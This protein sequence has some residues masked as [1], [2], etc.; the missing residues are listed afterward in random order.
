MNAKERIKEFLAF[1]RIGQNKF[2]KDC[3]FSDSLINNSKGSI[4]SEVLNKISIRWPE[5]NL[6]W[7]ITGQGE[8]INRPAPDPDLATPVSLPLP[9]PLALPPPQPQPEETV[10]T[11]EICFYDASAAGSYE[12]FDEIINHEKLIEK[13]V[14]PPFKD[15]SWMIPVRG[16]AMYPTYSNGDM[17]ACRVLYESKIIQWGRV[18]AIATR[19]QGILVKRV[20]KSETEDCL[21]ALSDNPAYKPFDIPKSEVVGMALVLGVI[22]ME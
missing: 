16:N 12:N 5:L 20:E 19:E 3:G 17:I 22:R 18:Y 11:N 8:M 14:V 7:V 6:S 2:A 4:G 9:L 13:F 10:H 21:L 1:K 15:I